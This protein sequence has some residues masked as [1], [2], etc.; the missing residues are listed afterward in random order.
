MENKLKTETGVRGINV[1]GLHLSC[2][3]NYCCG[4]G[5]R[6]PYRYLACLYFVQRKEKLILTSHQTVFH[7]GDN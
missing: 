3:G 2:M 4:G 1:T 5:G 6:G 7:K